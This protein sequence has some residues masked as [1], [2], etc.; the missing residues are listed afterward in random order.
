MFVSVVIFFKLLPIA[1]LHG[2]GL[3]L[4]SSYRP[5]EGTRLQSCSELPRVLSAAAHDRKPG[6]PKI[7]LRMLALPAEAGPCPEPSKPKLVG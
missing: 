2:Q 7:P 5:V 4:T 3:D 6:E 1:C